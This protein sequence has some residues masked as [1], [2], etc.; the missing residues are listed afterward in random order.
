MSESSSA[1]KSRILRAIIYLHWAAPVGYIVALTALY[2][3]SWTVAV[4][5]AFDLTYLARSALNIWVGWVLF[6]SK[7]W[8]WHLYVTNAVL[9]ALEQFYFGLFLSDTHLVYPSIFIALMAIALG[10]FLVKIEFRVPYFSPRISWWESDPRFRIG[11]PVQITISDHFHAGEILDISASGCF[12]K[13]KI[14]PEIESLLSLRF[15][16]FDRELFC[17]GRVVWHTESALTHPRGIGVRFTN[18]SKDDFHALKNAAR[19][20]RGIS[21]KMHLERREEKV[22]SIEKKLKSGLDKS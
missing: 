1:S 21:K 2:N 17:K 12:I 20:L 6:R 22:S 4:E 7:P 15:S 18:L 9:M 19:K 8:A 14:K 16:I 10:V 5:T 3:L 11:V 13:T